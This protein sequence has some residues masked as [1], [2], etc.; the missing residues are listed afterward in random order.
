MEKRLDNSFLK[1]LLLFILI[2]QHGSCYCTQYLLKQFNNNHNTNLVTITC[3]NSYTIC[4]LFF[5]VFF[6][7]INTFHIIITVI[8]HRMWSFYF[9]NMKLRGIQMDIVSYYRFD[10]NIFSVHEDT[11]NKNFLEQYWKRCLRTKH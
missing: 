3:R 9:H 4:L 6:Y 2:C 11:E 10:R 8:Q 7:I 5:F 1:L